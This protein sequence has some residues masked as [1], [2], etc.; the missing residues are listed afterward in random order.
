MT[1]IG[2]ARLLNRRAPGKLVRLQGPL[3]NCRALVHGFR[4]MLGGTMTTL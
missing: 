2:L 1:A 4:G 3:F